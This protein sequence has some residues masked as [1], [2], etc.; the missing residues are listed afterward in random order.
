L[1]E[2]SPVPER[3]QTG[4]L[5]VCYRR[6]DTQDAAG[7]LHD[8]LVEAYGADAVFM[9][10][11]MPL[12]VDFVDHVTEKLTRC[13]AV[14]VMMG[15]NWLEAADKRGRRRLDNADDLVRAEIAV[16][17][18]QKILVVPVLVQNASMPL[19]EDLPDDIRLIARR[20]GI[21]LSPT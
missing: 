15:K 10:I 16:A 1:R 6:D 11:D 2:G 5:F 7:R 18:K 19:A 4:T 12:G 9:D 13:R 17:L 14:I 8:R 3:P 20:N 21:E